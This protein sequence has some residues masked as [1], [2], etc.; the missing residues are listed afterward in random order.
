M[1]ILEEQ[2]AELTGEEK[3]AL[4]EELLAEEQGA[5][6]DSF[7]LSFSQQRLWFLHQMEPE[8]AAYNVPR[9]VRLAGDLDLPA[10]AGSFAELVR[11]HESLR[12]IF[13]LLDEGPVQIV[14]PELAIPLSEVDLRRLPPP[15]REGEATRA[16]VAAAGQPFDLATGPLVR[17]VLL[18]VGPRESILL[19]DLHHIIS[20]GWSA[21]VFIRELVTL[22]EAF[23]RGLPSPLPELSLQYVDYAVSQREWLQGEELEEMLGYWR[24]RLSGAPPVLDLPADRPRP[25][26]RSPHGGAAPLSL[27]P[28]LSR[29]VREAGRRLGA[30][31][32]M[33]LLAAFAALLHRYTGQADIVVGSDIANRNQ[34]ETE[35]LIG[36]FVNAL[37]LRIDLAG[38]PTFGDLVLRVR[39]VLL[40]AY[41]HQDL[42]FERLVEELRPERDGSYSPLFQVAFALQN[43]PAGSADVPGLS[44]R[45]LDVP[46]RTAK[47]D[48]ALMLFEGE[49]GF[50]GAVEYSADLFDPTTALRLLGH[51]AGLLA[52]GLAAPDLRVAELPFLPAAERQQALVEWNDS[53]AASPGWGATFVPLFA[54]RAAADPRAVAVSERDRDLTYGELDERAGRLAALLAAA[55][56]K[57]GDVVPLLAARSIDFL[58][59]LLGI[60][61]AG[62]AY[63]PLD[64]LHPAARWAQVLED[65]GAT[66]VL[67]ERSAAAALAAAAAGPRPPRLLVLEDLLAREDAAPA[68][69]PLP[70]ERGLAYVIYTSGSTGVPKGAMVEHRGL[71]NHLQAKI[72]ALELTAADTVAQTASQC[73]DVSVWQFLAP[74]L[75]GGRVRIYPDEVARNPWRLAEQVEADGVTIL[76]TVPAL[77][78]L[79]LDELATEARHPSFARLRWLIP[80]GEALPPELCRRWLALYPAV[81][82]LNAYGPTECS[83]DVTH[84]P[85]TTAPDLATLRMPIGRPVPNLRLHVLDRRLQPQPVG[86]PGELYV[87]GAGVGRGYLGAGGKTAD[88]WRPDPFAGP[89]EP[90]AR[91]YRTG[92]LALWR[93][94]GSLEFLGRVDHQVKIRGQR[95]ELGEI[96]AV[97]GEHPLLRTAAVL[98]REDSPGDPRLVAYV[99]PRA[100]SSR[101]EE[102]APRLRDFLAERLPEAMVPSAFVVL[103]TLPLLPNGKLDR[104]ALPPPEGG[105]AAPAD[106]FVAPQ[107]PTE[108]LIA[109]IWAEVLGA[110][111]IGAA[112]DFFDLGGHSLL[113]TQVTSRVRSRLGVE[114]PLRA[115]FDAPT[116]SLLARTVEA[117]LAGRAPAAPA[118]VRAP[119]DRDLPL[120][121][122][123]ERFWLLDQI[124]ASG[125]AYHIFSGLRLRGSLDVPA[126]AASLREV[127]RR[128]EILRT[129][130]PDEGGIPVQR[131][132]PPPPAFPIPL[133]DLCGLAETRAEMERLVAAERGRPFDL[134]HGPLVRLALLRLGPAEHLA[135]LDLHHIVSDGW[136]TNLLVSELAALYE[137]AARGGVATLPDLPV[138]YADYAA[139]QREQLRG[140]ALA[141]HLS[142]WAGRLAGAPPR[143]DLPYDH[144]PHPGSGGSGARW[145]ERLPADLAEAARAFARG[146]GATLF[147]TLLAALDIALFR[148]TGQ[149]DLVVGTV[150]ATRDRAELEKLIGCFLNFLPLRTALPAEGTG[151]STLERVRSGVL[152]AYAHRDCPFEKIVGELAPER[153][154]DDNPLYNVA[155]LLQ[156]FVHPKT[157]GA[158]L[159]A[160]PE[161]FGNPAALLDLRLIAEEV[162]EGLHLEWEYRADLFAEETIRLV[163]QAFRA[164]LAELVERPRTPLARFPLPAGLAEQA[165][166]SRDRRRRGTVAV[167]ATFTAE[168]VAEPLLFWLR[169][170]G[171]GS[172]VELAPYDQVFQQLLDPGSLL[173]G[174]SLGVNALLVRWEDWLRGSEDGDARARLGRAARELADA[175]RAAAGRGMAPCLVAVCPPSPAAL[176]DPAFAGFA[177]LAREL[178]E[179]LAAALGAL[180]GIHLLSAAELAASCPADAVH[181]PGADALGRVPYT[182]LFFT[183]L[184]TALARRLY[185]LRRPPRKVIALD[186]D[187]TLWRGVCGEDG[188]SGIEIDPP[189][190]ALQELMRAQQEAGM[191]LCLCSK[192]AEEDV[193]QVFAERGDM[194]L[195]LA[196]FVSWRIDWEPKADN[197]RALAV[198]LG[199]GLDSF[200][201][202]DDDPVQCAA[203]RAACPEVLVLE[204]PE[205]PGRIPG[206][207]ASVWAFDRLRVTGE[208][209]QRTALYQE[210]AE[211]ER[212]R[213]RSSSL[214]EFLAGLALEVCVAP[215]A[216]AELER[217]AQ[218]TQRTNQFNTTTLRRS[219]AEVQALVHGG[220]ELLATRVRDRFGDYGLVGVLLLAQRRETPEELRVESF[221][222]SCRALGRGV[223]HRMLAHAGALAFERGLAWVGVDFTPTGRNRPALDFLRSAA[224]RIAGAEEDERGFRFP[225]AGAAALTQD[226]IA[227]SP[228]PAGEGAEGRPAPAPGASAERESAL[229]HRFGRDLYGL[230]RIHAA[231]EAIELEQRKRRGPAGPF[232][233]PRSATEELLSGIFAEVLRLDRLGVH[234]DFF[235]LGGHSLLA[236]Q[237][238]S[239]V[240]SALGVELDLRALFEQPTV[241]GLARRVDRSAAPAAPP[242]L[243]TKRPRPRE[244]PL[245]FAQQRLWFLD[246]LEVSGAAY[247]VPLALRV[248]GPFDTAILAEALRRVA[249]RHE[250]LRT[251]FAAAGGRPVQVISPVAAFPL[252]LEDLRPLPESEREREAERRIL[253]EAARPFDLARGPLARGLALR[254]GDEEHRIVLTLHHIV[255]DGWSLGVLLR[256]LGEIYA[257]LAAGR[258]PALPELP[259]QYAD[260]ALWQRDLLRGER[261][262]A[263]IAWWR[264]QLT[265]AP[266][267]LELPADGPRP[268]V[269]SFRGAVRELALPGP[270]AASLETLAR[271]ADATLFM[272]LLAAFRA[273][274]HRYTGQE[275]LVVGSPIANR[276][277]LEIEPLIGFFVNTLALRGHLAGDPSFRELVG[278]EREATL[279]AYAHQDLPFEKLVEELHPQRDLGH[280]PLFQVM[281]ILQNAPLPELSLPD[282]H[283]RTQTLDLG[284]ASFDLTLS[285]A[286][287][288]RGLS[289]RLEHNADLF[290]AARSDRLLGHYRTLLEAAVDDPRRPAA[291]LPLLAAAE[292]AQLVAG[293]GRGEEPPASGRSLHQLFAAQA[294]RTPERIAL[295]AGEARLT[296]RELG[297]RAARLAERLRRQGVGPEVRVAIC[298]PRSSALVVGL[299]AVLQAGGAYVPLD[300]AYPA[301][302][303]AWMVADSRAA[304]L[305]TEGALAGSLPASGARIVLLD[306]LDGETDP[307]AAVEELAGEAGPGNTAYVIYTSG[308]TGRPKGV[309]LEHRN[310]V[311]LLDWAQRF[312]APE[313]LA[314]VLFST[315]ISFDLSVFELFAPLAAGGKAIL[316]GTALDFHALPAAAEV[317]LVNTVPSAMAELVRQRPLPAGVRAVAL[318]GE[319]LPRSLARSV[320]ERSAVRRLLN[321]YGP[322][323]G[324]T[325]ST[326]AVVPAE[327][328]AAPSIGRPIAGTRAGLFDPRLLPV[329]DGIPGELCIGGAGLARAYLGRPDLT[330]ERFVPDPLAPRPGERLYRT[331]DLARRSPSGELEFLGRLDQQV[332][333]RGFRIEAGEVEEALLRHPAVAEAAVGARHELADRRLVAWLTIRPGSPAPSP[334][335]LR[336][337]LKESLPEHLIPSAFVVLDALPRTPNGKVDRRALPTPGAAR[338][339]GER[340][341]AA[342]R[343]A[344]EEVLA[345]LWAEVLGIERVGVHDDFF[346]LGGHSLLATQVVSRIAETLSPELHL[347]QLFATPTVAGLAAS[348]LESPERRARTERV[349]ALLLDLAALSEDEAAALLEENA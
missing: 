81:R 248:A 348:L 142:W 108:E 23:S 326:A 306:L 169:Q 178:E 5:G 9:A 276:N 328:A 12:T 113:A 332:K 168:P 19:V 253:A 208:D 228:A 191:L 324:S 240:R 141:D 199:L 143:L 161:P 66:T 3:R 255:S 140:A 286:R 18:H 220:S 88:A 99:V 24:A 14:L 59:A 171:L 134:A 205:D 132:A 137:A 327:G 48:L 118:L 300:P 180:P 272:V 188:P 187:Q 133:I 127:V 124:L 16:L 224:R 93:P 165:A 312:F 92:D 160:A 97:L 269:Q 109:A 115:L 275:D 280:T 292:L 102:L 318:A 10:L 315:S 305:L 52:E 152:E 216:A 44:V 56:V 334:G 167:A 232:V 183:A 25:A 331:G 217:V 290:A 54:A 77:L 278:R 31:P 296:Y 219:A 94:D 336:E 67:C 98:A 96:E 257:G 116:V 71:L 170:L 26:V 215:M 89:G 197:L 60:F 285:L 17:V 265:D 264:T 339:A 40:G 213:E 42:P 307:G 294:A 316:A 43:T 64:P 270:L 15:E 101:R 39:E 175:L 138:Q 273:L 179:E 218:L 153:D 238:L 314:G 106:A 242:P 45:P 176:A 114:L 261:L 343:N 235:R 345:G 247:N 33:T 254:V 126:L 62:A 103:E 75:V 207:L 47:F 284:T 329:P 303:L 190:R 121:F 231:I 70:A 233:A 151:L 61:E 110:E 87:G 78:R 125:S 192:N 330:A 262:A 196:H 1:S 155:L 346:D 157:F 135:L 267:V 36:F 181:D 323:E 50:P 277:R 246:Q 123:Q 41:A 236:T 189:R 184:G 249:A 100:E 21:G 164:A 260:F 57:P 177:D 340:A 212:L 299:L 251:T 347:R 274:L 144:P 320:H 158:R 84:Q 317:T 256:D 310:A 298:A 4:L 80:T 83:D 222:L 145:Q 243:I 281:F 6:A 162:P 230:E 349:A 195:A 344:V 27:G 139:W 337:A 156:N 53:A 154:L 29:R 91:L 69:L 49:E 321:L 37:V 30:T 322:S 295:V 338:P 131:I 308:S 32:F 172:R 268:A 325:Y 226:P 11:R 90:G 20:D 2:I 120:S 111:R 266:P 287:D 34:E 147:M 291:E 136:S 252:A 65:C 146:Q 221:L 289:A 203:V 211:R 301:E 201:L 239:R 122:A 112:D 288:E 55:G 283:L 309:V 259:V 193:L 200:I 293:D 63:L 7:P 223:E 214:A 8:S 263:E 104:Q 234:D 173:S 74:L 182:P 95:I 225:A 119:R 209:R 79:L 82:L 159:A 22:Y 194:P 128:H 35:G 237:L 185:A 150:V 148:W 313:E 319:P 250:A 38:D 51:Y 302:R 85:I 210:N 163:A 204:L 73:F 46:L 341:Y 311:A 342:P 72:A 202:V 58:V 130:F 129:A 297:E 117:A 229:F 271:R 282:L 241:A 105:H 335:E 244:I 304:V 227:P 245:S 258:S 206:F 186:C 28:D 279:G 107:G 68:P 76:E 198:E 149:A 86:V 333:V 13:R 174:N 166:R